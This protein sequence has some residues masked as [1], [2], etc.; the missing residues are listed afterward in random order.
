M[1]IRLYFVARRSKEFVGCGNYDCN[2]SQ[3]LSALAI[4]FIPVGDLNYY[5]HERTVTL[6]VILIM[7]KKSNTYVIVMTIL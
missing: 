5:H 2:R 3:F 6:Y 1:S 4:I 7:T